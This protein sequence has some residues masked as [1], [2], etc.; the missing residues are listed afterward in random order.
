MSALTSSIPA[1]AI[2]TSSSTWE[3]ICQLPLADPSFGQPGAIDVIIGSDQLWNLYNGERKFF[4]NDFP[5]A[6]FGW[7]IAGSYSSADEDSTPALAHHAQLDLDELVR[8]FMEMDRV[9]PPKAVIDASDPSEQHFAKTHR[10]NKDGVYVVQYPFKNNAPPI[11]ATLPQ[12]LNRLHSLERKLLRFP[13][14]RQQYF[15]FMDDYLS[16]GH[17]EVLTSEQIVE[18]PATCVYL[19]HHAVLKPNSSTTKCRVVFDGSGKDA[20]GFS[21]NDRLQVGPPIQ[22]DLIG[23]CL[24]FRQHRYVFCADIEKMFC[25]I[26]VAPEHTNYLRIIW[27]KNEDSPISH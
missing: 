24:R 16:R 14:L 22:R 23:V 7:V 25:G 11:G 4:G 15:D 17:M 19:A 13:E 18:D 12:A 26:Q 3:Q 5:I 6:V 1:Q 9:L 21:L 8:S 10:R 2:N 20:T 27:R